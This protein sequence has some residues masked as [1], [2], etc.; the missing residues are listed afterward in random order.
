MTTN[1]VNYQQLYQT[2][3][4]KEM[5]KIPTAKEIYETEKSHNPHLMKF[6]R[7]WTHYDDLNLKTQKVLYLE[8]IVEF[9]ELE[10]DLMNGYWEDLHIAMAE[11]ILNLNTC[12]GSSIL[13]SYSDEESA[14]D[15]LQNNLDLLK[16]IVL[17]YN[18]L[19][20]TDYD[21]DAI[22][23]EIKDVSEAE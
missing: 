4:G 13:S 19:F 14:L 9:K 20:D 5:P 23:N 21:E 18:Q 1:D 15:A 3:F 7:K 10:S 2:E 11:M 8:A 6:L 22:L 12:W 17:I 16:G